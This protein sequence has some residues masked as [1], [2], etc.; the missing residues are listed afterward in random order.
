MYKRSY[1]SINEAYNYQ[2]ARSKSFKSFNQANRGS[3]KQLQ[4][5]KTISNLRLT[6]HAC[7]PKP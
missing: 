7:P 5:S 2:L 3:D 6:T 4:I 1:T